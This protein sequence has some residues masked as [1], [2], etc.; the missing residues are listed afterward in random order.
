M[1][2]VFQERSRGKHDEMEK[3]C[4]RDRVRVTECRAT[5]SWKI[6]DI[7]KGAAEHMGPEWIDLDMASHYVGKAFIAADSEEG[8]SEIVRQRQEQRRAGDQGR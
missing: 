7:C 8:V 1:A 5:S 3:C 4:R 6:H 2:I